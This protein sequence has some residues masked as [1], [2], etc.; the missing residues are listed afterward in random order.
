VK[1]RMWCFGCLLLT[2]F[3]VGCGEDTQKKQDAEKLRKEVGPNYQLE[4]VQD[5][6]P[7]DASNP[8]L[9]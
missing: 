8:S 5:D 9:Q 6:K 2:A 4:G 1:M 3:T 7:A